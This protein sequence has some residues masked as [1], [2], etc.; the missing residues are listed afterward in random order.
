[1]LF[2]DD[3]IA[4]STVLTSRVAA[5]EETGVYE[6]NVAAFLPDAIECWVAVG[7][8]PRAAR[9]GEAALGQHAGL[10]MPWEEGRTLLVVGQIRRRAGERRRA[11]E[12]I[13]SAIETF[14]ASAHGRGKKGPVV[15]WPA[16]VFG[17]LRRC[18]PKT[19]GG[20]A[21]LAVSGESNPAI[22]ARMFISVRTVEANLSR[23]HRKLGI[24]RRA[25]W[26]GVGP[27]RRRVMRP[28]PLEGALQAVRPNTQ[29]RT[30]IPAAH[31][32]HVANASDFRCSNQNRWLDD[33]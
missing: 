32:G 6:M 30:S 7:E 3:P 12:A 23:A 18:S 5:V 25:A 26:G 9:L 33:K 29:E 16:L 22:A 2:D 27:R 28:G 31:R 15:S 8:I 17:A 1:M 24:T 11:R 20:S 19:S 4:A 10:S 14:T 13:G 21:N